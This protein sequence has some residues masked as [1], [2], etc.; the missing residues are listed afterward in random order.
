[1]NIRQ[2]QQLIEEALG[3][4]TRSLP[5]KPANLYEPIRYTLALGGKRMRPLLTLMGAGL[6]S[7]DVRNALPAAKAIEL[8]HNFTLL[9]DDIMD[10]APLRRGQPSVHVKWNTS[11]A[12][13]SGDVMYTEA[14]R[15][16]ALSPKTLL[17]EVL[18]I[19]TQTALEVCEGQQHDVDFESQEDVRISDY[20]E[21]I[22]LKTAVLLAASL[23]IGALCGN[24]SAEEAKRLY[25]FGVHVGIAFQ[26]QDDILDVFADSE[27]F[28]KTTGGDIVSN[29]K[30]YLL[31]KAFELANRYQKEELQHWLLLPASQ[32]KEKVEG[33]KALY[34]QLGVRKAAE[35]EMEKQY[36]NG[37][38]A[39]ETVN[40]GPE[41]KAV[42]KQ[43]ADELMVRRH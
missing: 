22:R 34:D 21:M 3:E 6:F 32:A 1:M 31:L 36:A 30:T 13:L 42:L 12:I 10:Q 38:A 29:K 15:Q 37:I 18:G 17:P 40:A 24:A 35:E 28:G 25:D 14:F 11:I 16:A 4:F 8:F 9:H 43:F 7:D 19:F 33:V 26:L 20:M 41:R 5:A 27:K 23:Q 2:Y 39:L